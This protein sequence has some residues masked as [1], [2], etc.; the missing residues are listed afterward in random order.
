MSE[1]EKNKVEAVVES[2]E[3]KVIRALMMGFPEIPPEKKEEK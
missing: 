3:D 1:K 2:Y